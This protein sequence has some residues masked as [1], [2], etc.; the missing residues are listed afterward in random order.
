MNGFEFDTSAFLAADDTDLEFS[1]G[2]FDMADI[3]PQNNRLLKPRFSTTPVTV[4]Y[5]Y[6]REM[7][8]DIKLV[9]GEQIHCLVGGNFVFGDLFEALLTEK[10]VVA[11]SMHVAT[12]S[13]S[14]NN[15]DSFRTLLDAGLVESLSVVVSNYFYSHERKT[16]IPYMMQELDSGDRFELSVLRNHTKIVLMDIGNIRL[17]MTGSANLRSSRSVEQFAL[18]ESRELYDFYREWFDNAARDYSI[19]NREVAV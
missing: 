13:L 10:N 4:S 11:R 19:I 16:L 7:A 14:Q 2:D 6:A 8:R 15:I 18:Q 3:G 5:E 12:L 9:P 17:V 1:I